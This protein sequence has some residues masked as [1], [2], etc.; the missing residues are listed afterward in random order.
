MNWNPLLFPYVLPSLVGAALTPIQ[1]FSS[2]P[3]FHNLQT[4]PLAGQRLTSH[5]RALLLLFGTYLPPPTSL[6]AAVNMPA[7]S[8]STRVPLEVLSDAVLEEIKTRC[9]FV[10]EAMDTA[11]DSSVVSTMGE[12]PM[13]I[14]LAP[15]DSALSESDFSRVSADRDSN[16]GPASDFSI[17]SRSQVL[18]GRPS[19]GEHQLQALA[20]LYMRHSTATDLHLKVTPPAS[21]QTGTGHGTL[22]VPGWIRERGSEVLFEGGDVDESSVAETIL[23]C[24]LK[25]QSFPMRRL[26]LTDF[27]E[28]RPQLIFAGHSLPPFL[29]LAA[30]RCSRDLS[31]GCTQNLSRQS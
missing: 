18:P 13:D 4:S 30:L 7:S 20:D 27:V 10:G 5:L 3:L 9:S 24:L 31:R 6:S 26:P 23:E 14:D 21:Q 1:I 15:S 19:A 25:V 8:R 16:A 2:R 17:V 22:I 28:R 29:L 11:L 12:D